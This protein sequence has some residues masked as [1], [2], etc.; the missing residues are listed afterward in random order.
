MFLLAP[1]TRQW[2]SL[3]VVPC[4][5]YSAGTADVLPPPRWV[6][7]TYQVV[8]THSLAHIALELCHKLFALLQAHYRFWGVGG[9]I[10]LNEAQ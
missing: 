10:Q 3:M 1:P 2:K 7:S 5:G 4:S 6:P 8:E 9:H